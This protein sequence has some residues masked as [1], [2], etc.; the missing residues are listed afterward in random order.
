[1]M[2]M[3]HFNNRYIDDELLTT[4]ITNTTKKNVIRECRQLTLGLRYV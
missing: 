4:M 1:M 2:M 3:K